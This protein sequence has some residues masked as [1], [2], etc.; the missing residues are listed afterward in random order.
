MTLKSNCCYENTQTGIFFLCLPACRL[1]NS[2]P[3]TSCKGNDRIPEASDE[4][5][6]FSEI[7]NHESIQ[8]HILPDGGLWVNSFSNRVASIIV[9]VAVIASM[10]SHST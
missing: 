3:P 8:C 2:Y 7:T 5:W 10:I 9:T 4:E 1:T 6:A